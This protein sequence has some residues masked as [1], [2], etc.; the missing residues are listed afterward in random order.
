MK[1]VTSFP[2]KFLNFFDY[3]ITICL[4]PWSD[5]YVVDNPKRMILGCVVIIE[6]E[7]YFNFIN[8]FKN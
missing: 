2:Q 7:I 1:Y 5:T 3:S 4:T 6:I 8:N